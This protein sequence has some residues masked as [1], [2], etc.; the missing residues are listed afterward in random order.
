MHWLA[1]TMGSPILWSVGTT[2]SCRLT[3]TPGEPVFYGYQCEQ[4][5]ANTCPHNQA[6]HETLSGKRVRTTLQPGGTR[7][8]TILRPEVEAIL[9]AYY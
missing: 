1:K 6:D 3:I 5:A 9:P 8:P 7:P 4:M 2:L